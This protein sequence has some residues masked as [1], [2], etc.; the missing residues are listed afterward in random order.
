MFSTIRLIFIAAFILFVGLFFILSSGINVEKFSFASINVSKLYIKLDKKLIVQIEEIELPAT[1]QSQ[2]SV[3]DFKKHIQ[4][5]PTLLTIFQKIDIESLKIKNNEFTITIDEE[6]FYIDNKFINLSAKPLIQNDIVT[7]NLYSLFLK[8]YNLLFDGLLKVNLQSDDVLFSGKVLYEDL[9]ISLNAQTNDDV[10]DF[11]LKSNHEFPNIHFIKDF[12]TLDETIEEWMYQN[13][14]G[15]MNLEY[16]QGQLDRKTFLPIVSSLDGVATIKDADITFNKAVQNVKT[17]AI[18]VAFKNDN[19]YFDLE[20]PMYNNIS[21]NGSNVVIHALSKEEEASN[22]VITLKTKNRLNKDVLTILKAYEIDLPL[23]QQSGTT[24]AEL[25]IQIYFKNDE[26]ITK[27]VFETKDSRFSL[28]GFEFTAKKALVELDNSTVSIKNSNVFVDNLLTANLNLTIDTNTNLA[29]GNA[30]VNNLFVKTDAVS[31]IDMNNI[32]T[33]VLIDYNTFTKINLPHLFT[34]ISLLKDF[35]RIELSN[36][37]FLYDKSKLLQDLKIE[38]GSLSLYLKDKENI[39]F[40]GTLTKFDFPIVQKDGNKLQTLTLK[41]EVKNGNVVVG[42][43]DEKIKVEITDNKNHLFLKDYDILKE[44]NTLLQD[45]SSTNLEIIGINSTVLLNDKQKLLADNYVL[46]LKNNTMNLKLSHKDGTFNYAQDAKKSINLTATAVSDIFMNQLMGNENFFDEGSFNLTAKGNNQL[47]E[48][49]VDVTNAKINNLALINNLVTFVNTTPAL[50]NPLLAIPT[51]FGMAKNSGFNLT[52]YKIVEGH[53]DFTYDTKNELF[54]M[55]HLETIGNMTDFKVTGLIN[56]EQKNI[57]ADVTLIF[58]KDYSSIIDYVPVFN[59]LLLG[60]EKNIS[61]QL[62]IV[63]NLDNPDIQTNFTQD[64]AGAPVN[65][66]KRI[67]NLPAKG[68][69][70]LTPSN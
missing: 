51:L 14:T 16:L 15:V 41:G 22:I 58:L 46:L 30:K 50:I 5:V 66:I 33:D 21:I 27:G 67:F 32:T 56:L 11:V 43:S 55:K 36:L 20:N 17:K 25:A 3:N 31:L 12:I 8:D 29:S 19:L 60:D 13:V 4:Y 38:E 47:L 9:D 62:R 24:N 44:N 40:K 70:L 64:A 10:I 23:V 45:N 7:L 68:I 54:Y 61:T 1:S 69:E 28:N 35:T 48:G 26:M 49:R 59:Y 52:G 53:L 37:A 2:N 34:E 18:T 39:D 42:S 65:F 57:D 6:I 63:G